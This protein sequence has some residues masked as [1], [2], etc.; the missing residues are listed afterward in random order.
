MKLLAQIAAASLASYVA[1]V[2][3]RTFAR[4]VFYTIC[5]VMLVVPCVYGWHGHSVPLPVLATWLP[6]LSLGCVLAFIGWR[7]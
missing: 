3:E 4:I 2:I 7:R 6:M 1:G 5:L